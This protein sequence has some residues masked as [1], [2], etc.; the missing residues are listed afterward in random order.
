MRFALDVDN[1]FQVIARAGGWDL[2][3]DDKTVFYARD[4]P[5]AVRYVV[6]TMME[7]VDATGVAKVVDALASIESKIESMM[8]V[9]DLHHASTIITPL[10]TPLASS[11]LDRQHVVRETCLRMTGCEL[12]EFMTRADRHE[13]V[14]KA[15][16]LLEPWFQAQGI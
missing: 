8:Q 4:L 3:V 13:I 9:I 15:K 5:T 7:E 12:E 14:T 16:A 2:V 10:I 1:R 11:P 6:E